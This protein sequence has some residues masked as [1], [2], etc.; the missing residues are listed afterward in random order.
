MNKSHSKELGK[1]I[2]KE[3]YWILPLFLSIITLLLVGFN[4]LSNWCNLSLFWIRLIIL[5]VGIVLIIGWL[6]YNIGNN[7]HVLLSRLHFLFVSAKSAWILGFGFSFLAIGLYLFF[8][9]QGQLHARYDTIFG[10]FTTILAFTVASSILYRQ[11]SPIIGTEDLI[12]QICND[13]ENLDKEKNVVFVYRALNIG[14]Y[15][16][17]VPKNKVWSSNTFKDGHPLEKLNNT[18]LTKL[19]KK[20]PK[21]AL[22]ITYNET[23]TKELYTAYD[24]IKRNSLN[25]KIDL[26][27]NDTIDACVKSAK[28]LLL[29][30]D[31]KDND[32][33]H[34]T[35]HPTRFPNDVF[36]IGDYVYITT[37]YGMPV[38]NN[39]NGVFDEESLEKEVAEL[40]TWRRK[41][42]ILAKSILR[43][44]QNQIKQEKIINKK[45]KQ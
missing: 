36:I 40:V 42:P 11:M 27:E 41:D 16:D 8:P 19:E 25:G 34:E 30:F 23:M 18:L 13:I 17:I 32:F 15:R 26:N 1:N 12:N 24:K 29:R 3:L 21:L 5:I 33:I 7:S 45:P 43:H 35:F 4:E 38:F 37:S 28:E 22:A 31:R 20:A 14:F 6:L 10:I 2:L 44:L 39:E 9:T